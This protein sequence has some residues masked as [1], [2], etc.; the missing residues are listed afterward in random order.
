MAAIDMVKEKTRNENEIKSSARDKQKNAL[1]PK[2]VEM[3]ARRHVA[4][5]RDNED[6]GQRPEAMDRI[7]EV[8]SRVAGCRQG[9]PS[10][11]C[12]V[13]AVLPLSPKPAG[14]LRAWRF[15]NRQSGFW[16]SFWRLRAWR[17]AARGWL[18]V[19]PA[20]RPMHPRLL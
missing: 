17:P 19:P 9:Y 7:E 15:P 1:F 18:R 12:T 20:P 3:Q 5:A 13:I 8:F 4:M 11:L 6:D 10:S 16:R 2:R 14:S